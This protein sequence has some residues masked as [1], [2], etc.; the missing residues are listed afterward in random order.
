M[1]LV[2]DFDKEK[3]AYVFYAFL[4]K[5]GIE[6]TYEPFQD[7]KSGHKR[8]HVWIYDEDEYE[9][10]LD[11]LERYRTHPN[12][13]LFQDVQQPIISTTPEEYPESDIEDMEWNTKVKIKPKLHRAALSLTN[14]LIV[15]CAALFLW[16][17]L[18]E[19]EILKAKGP[20][21]VQI[22]FTPLQEALIFDE[23]LSFRYIQELIDSY[24]L[25]NYKE[26]KELPA[27]AQALFQKAES[28][29]MWRGIY[30]A[31]VQARQSGWDSLR[32]TPMFEK[33]S[34]GEI[35]RIF[36]PCLLHR[37]F[38]HILFNMAWL[39]VLGKQIEQRLKRW[40]M[41]LL[42]IIIGVVSN[43]AQYL[44]SGPYFLGFSGVVVGMAGF[45]WM[46]QRCAP[47]EG[48][49]L[50]KATALF[51]LFFVGA[52]FA[53]ELLV[54]FLQF[55]NIGNLSANIAN[56]AHIIGGLCGMVLGRF[57]FFSRGGK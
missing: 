35:W 39:W 43:V 19:A 28:A 55:F 22:S 1:R 32:N 14:L 34:E 29:P 9:P 51:I 54:F 27:D 24:P 57:S 25:Q 16:N 36:T 2:G 46:R 3:E 7:K 38:L 52:M 8:Y 12:D 40:K 18:Q 15:L 30:A 23:P 47:W 49:P 21:A 10:A 37:D 48:Y 45:I 11:W 53:L 4:L 56:T 20:L 31:V 42:I 17:N 41:I 5:E 50:Q 44:M 33:I 26:L 13:P 6:N